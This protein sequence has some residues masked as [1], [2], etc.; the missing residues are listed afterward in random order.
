M[1]PLCLQGTPRELG[2]AHGMALRRQ[3]RS[4][5]DDDLARL[6]RVLLQQTSL[7]ALEPEIAAYR[8][9][10][11]AA[12]PSLAEEI[13]G[14]AEGAGI[15]PDEAMLLQIRREVMGYSRITTAGDCTTLCQRGEGGPV[16]A[17][18]IDLNGNLEDQMVILRIAH[19]AHSRRV[20]LL[21]FTGLL[22]YLGL[23]S[24]GLAIGLNLVLGG[25][26][27]PG[28][29]PYLAIRHLLDTCS[30]I[31]SCLGWL[32]GAQLAS[33]RSLLL[34]DAGRSVIVELCDGKLSVRDG[35]TLVHTNHFLSE[36][37][38]AMDQMNP[39]SRNSSMRRLDACVAQLESLDG[40]GSAGDLMTL[41]C[42]EPIN[43][44]DTGNIRREK[45]VGAVVLLPKDG[46]LHVRRGDP[47]L[48]QTE[49]FCVDM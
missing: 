17:Q 16:L 38:V 46:E 33:S 28:I 20:L 5:L 19:R 3:I 27:R 31:E 41:L 25:T 32:S 29:P 1:T 43:V 11:A 2:R 39:F 48:A 9:E 34:C 4:F 15:S 18:T 13:D 45:T 22:G 47:A 10:I 14:M 12:T 42:R 30:D 26:W 40:K 7:S 49:K 8:R 35:A 37:F 24:D 36:E 21:S 23:N 44:P 6:N